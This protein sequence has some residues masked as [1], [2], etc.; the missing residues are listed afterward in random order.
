[1]F[2]ARTGSTVA[3]LASYGTSDRDIAKQMARQV[4]AIFRGT[5]AGDLPVERPRNL[6][7]TINLK[8]AKKIGLTIPPELLFR[9]DKVIK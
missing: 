6:E 4:A 9:A 5:K 3:S 1:M 2:H 7:L 8:T